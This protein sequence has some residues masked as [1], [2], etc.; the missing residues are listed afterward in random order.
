MTMASRTA[1]VSGDPG[2]VGNWGD[3][4]GTVSLVVEAALVLLSASM[5]LALR[6]TTVTRMVTDHDQDG[7]VIGSHEEP[8]KTDTKD[9]PVPAR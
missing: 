8:V 4:V 5:L 6:H 1:G 9:K 2:D 3:W 7:H